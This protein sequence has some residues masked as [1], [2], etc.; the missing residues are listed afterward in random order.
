MDYISIGKR[1][2]QLPGVNIAYDAQRDL[3][4]YAPC[5]SGDLRGDTHFESVAL[6]D[7]SAEVFT[8]Y[9]TNPG[10]LSEEEE[11]DLSYYNACSYGEETLTLHEQAQLV[12][13]RFNHD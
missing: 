4:R 10:N 13:N 9:L 12:H 5:T 2:I 1:L 6:D 8:H 3:R 11:H 7:P